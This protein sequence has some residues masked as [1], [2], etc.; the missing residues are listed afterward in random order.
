MIRAAII[1]LGRI[2]SRFDEELSRKV[3]WTHAGAYLAHPETYT[4]AGAV[5]IRSANRDAFKARCPDIPVFATISELIETVRPEL[6]SVCTPAEHHAAAIGEVLA[7]SSVRA[8]WCEKPLA[9]SAAD[10]DQIADAVRKRG[11][12]VIVSYVRRWLPLWRRVREVIQGG[13]IGRLVSVRIAMPN[14]LFTLQSHAID[15]AL[16]LGGPVKAYS[17]QQIEYLQEDGEPASL[18]TLQFENRAY[19]IVQP[20]GRKA[21]L[22]IEAELFGDE[23]RMRVTE[24]DGSIHI[25][26]FEKSRRFQGYRQLQGE[27]TEMVDAFDTASPFIAI[28]EDI[29]RAWPS[30]LS[31]IDNLDDALQVE[32][33]M[34]AAARRN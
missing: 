34:T 1:G 2:G 28:V 22:V 30:G 3:V 9:L 32:A 13:E 6:V 16:F 10:S 21:D 27:R 31:R 33:I 11:V 7:E 19:G 26:R 20:T 18:I 25:S 29:A 24:H 4:L 8:V 12:S 15:L 5:E 23:G 17:A 14:R